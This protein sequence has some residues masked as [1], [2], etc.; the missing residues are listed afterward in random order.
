[1]NLFFPMLA[2]G[3]LTGFHCVTMCGS[4]V[5]SYSVGNPREG[6]WL[7]R[8]SPQFAYQAAKILSYISMGLLLG[9]I[10]AVFNL[11]GVRNWA[12]IVAGVFMILVGLQLTGWFPALRKFS[13]RAPKFLVQ[14]IMS[15]RKRSSAKDQAA[16]E[17]YVTPVLFGLMTGLMP[18]GPLIAAEL[19]AAGSGSAANG[20]IAMLGFGLG[21]VPVMLAFGS[22]ASMISGRFQKWMSIT[23]AVVV[24]VLGAMFINRGAVLL[25]SP[26]SFESVAQAITGPPSTG[27]VAFA[28]DA[29]GVAEVKLTIKNTQFVP[30]VVTIPSDRPVKLVVD[31]QEDTA[32]SDQIAIPS[33]G[34]LQ[35]LK[36]NGTTVVDLPATK[37]GTYR[38]TCGM[39]MMSG[40]L[41]AAAANGSPQS[42]AAPGGAA[43]TPAG[44]AAQAP[45]A[46]QGDTIAQA[47][48]ASQGSASAGGGCCGG[49]GAQASPSA[50]APKAAKVVGGVQKISIDVSRGYYDPSN[51]VLK[52][53]I[54][55]EVMF[56]QSSG[57]TGQ[58]V[59][60]DLQFSE[61]LST[62]PKTVKIP[63]LKP[64]HFVFHCGMN[65][66]S[67]TITVQ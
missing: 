10:G 18:C 67:G 8:I 6:G 9:A 2:V 19:A 53:G 40:T 23:A 25:G 14:W 31:R 58:V 33:L 66:V 51:I 34:I 59:S 12:T 42:A 50:L 45:A 52:A 48:A 4:M 20:A 30:N 7:E 63:A 29:N 32:C 1:M 65:M 47:P 37:G 43:Q 38:L 60:E 49:A 46:T 13:P 24:I 22:V 15:L 3:L 61:D 41:V 54:P 21:T 16:T 44:V 11:A 17:A 5:F 27:A 57:C 56:S 39:G 28:Q 55:A 35:N 62:G 26:V 64:G 36:A